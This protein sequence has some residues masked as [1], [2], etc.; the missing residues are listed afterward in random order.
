MVK[1]SLGGKR[2]LKRMVWR[3]TAMETVP[4]L[5]SHMPRTW[6]RREHSTAPQQADQVEQSKGKARSV[7]VPVGCCYPMHLS[8]RDQV[9]EAGKVDKAAHEVLAP[10]V[11]DLCNQANQAS[12]V[13]YN[14]CSMYTQH[15]KQLGRSTKGTLII[16]VPSVQAAH[17]VSRQM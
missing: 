10:E 9:Q 6:W 7:W 12:S 13:C 8:G 3:K 17:G 2:R 14:A 16:R 15:D 4:A 5:S 11:E 1:V